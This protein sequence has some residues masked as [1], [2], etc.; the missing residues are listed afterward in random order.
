MSRVR[1]K[2]TAAKAWSRRGGDRRRPSPPGEGIL[3]GYSRTIEQG[4]AV[5]LCELETLGELMLKCGRLLLPRGWGNT[6]STGLAIL[7]VTRYE[8]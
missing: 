2:G 3:H 6:N 8:F 7:R 1:Q 5:D 4:E